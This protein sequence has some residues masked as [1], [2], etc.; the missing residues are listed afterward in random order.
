MQKKGGGKG[1][2]IEI[3]GNTHKSSKLLGEH[4]KLRDLYQELFSVWILQARNQTTIILICVEFLM[5][6]CPGA[7]IVYQFDTSPGSK[8]KMII[9]ITCMWT[10]YQT[11]MPFLSSFVDTKA[12]YEL[13]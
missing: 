9:I 5:C 6:L 4:K 13:V 3:K 10:F 8:K 1:G 11:E 12:Q 2:C 7:T